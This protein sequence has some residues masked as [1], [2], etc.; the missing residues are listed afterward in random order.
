MIV[1]PT[2]SEDISAL[3]LVLDGT[4]LF[5]SEMLPG[6]LRSFLSDEGSQD[7]WLT[8]ETDGEAVGFCYASPEAL[9]HG[10]WNMLAIAVLPSKHGSG[11]GSIMVNRLESY[12]WE[13]GHRV[14]IADTSGTA[15]FESTRRF[16][17]NNGY[18]EVARIPDFWADDD[19]K[20]VFWKK[21]S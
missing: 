6:M 9:T 3:K 8:C 7:V 19:D 14:L 13:R 2:K 4:G 1:R 10:T 11:A 20:V 5:P 16:Y 21:L 12:L 15:T 18:L 17:R